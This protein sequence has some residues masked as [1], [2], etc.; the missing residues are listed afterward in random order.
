MDHSTRSY[1]EPKIIK[2]KYVFSKEVV[3][4]AEDLR[5][6]YKCFEDLIF[7][8]TIRSEPESWTVNIEG[9]PIEGKDNINDR[10]I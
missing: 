2:R 8:G 1:L 5:E 9:L 7:S 6:A 3:I 10:T 4:I